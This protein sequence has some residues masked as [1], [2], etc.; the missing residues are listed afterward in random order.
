MTETERAVSPWLRGGRK[1]PQDIN[2]YTQKGNPEVSDKDYLF[3]K[4]NADS[5]MSERQ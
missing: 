1:F 2:P 4:V 3:R 5:E